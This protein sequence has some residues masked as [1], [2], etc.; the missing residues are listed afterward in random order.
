MA[1]GPVGSAIYVNQQMAT[2]ASEKN[3]LQNRFD[4]QN[5]AAAAAVNEKEKEVLEVR[6]AEENQQ[7]DP[8]REHQDQHSEEENPKER[9]EK[10]EKPT[11]RASTHILD[12][13]V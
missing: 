12:I 4:L 10:E 13:T 9:E 3:A 7:I 11:P 6:P 8:D 5:L 2:V 1:V